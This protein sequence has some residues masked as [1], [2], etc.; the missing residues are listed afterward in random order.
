MRKDGDDGDTK[1]DLDDKGQLGFSRG[2]PKDFLDRILQSAD[3]VGY[4]DI[5]VDRGL[6]S[7]EPVVRQL[8]RRLC[9]E[10][11]VH[12]GGPMMSGKTVWLPRYVF[13]QE[14][15]DNL[16]SAAA[17]ESYHAKHSSSRVNADDAG[18]YQDCFQM[19]EDVRINHK[20]FKDYKGVRQM[21]RDFTRWALDKNKD[22]YPP[23]YAQLVI[24]GTQAEGHGK[25]VWDPVLGKKLRRDPVVQ[26]IVVQARQARGTKH[27]IPLA[28][29]LGEHL[30]PDRQKKLDK[31]KQSREALQKAGKSLQGLEGKLQRAKQRAQDDERRL[32]GQQA[33]Q[34]SLKAEDDKDG[35]AEAEK[36][37][38]QTME[39]IKKQQEEVQDLHEQI[40]KIEQSE[41]YKKASSDLDVAKQEVRELRQVVQSMAKAMCMGLEAAKS[42]LTSFDA[43]KYSETLRQV[44]HD[45]VSRSVEKIQ[46]NESGKLSRRALHKVRTYPEQIW[47]TPVYKRRP[48]ARVV[49]LLDYSGSM[50]GPLRVPQAVARQRKESGLGRMSRI[51]LLHDT[52]IRFAKA[53]VDVSEEY[54]EG[55]VSAAAVWFSDSAYPQWKFGSEFSNEVKKANRLPHSGGGTNLLTA[56]RAGTKMLKEEDDKAC[57]GTLRKL[58]VVLTDTEYYNEQCDKYMENDLPPDM[59]LVCVSIGTPLRDMQDSTRKLFR[60]SVMTE[61]DVEDVLI[62]ALEEGIG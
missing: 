62:T 29:Q 27:V 3:L 23:E 31:V 57:S 1:A 21:Y 56:L 26:G 7:I 44:V 33:R 11:K 30:F 34:E 18:V 60:Y 49:F 9:M 12:D 2:S 59:Q 19:L 51:T 15:A 48:D 20:M 40:D 52:F 42:G 47:E 5:D 36:Q 6:V 35:A 16:L 13:S 24:I 10:V 4:G 22:N 37:A 14:E 38:D 53:L 61:D 54:E 28:V 32:S 58:M 46:Q 43:P 39:R 25:L 50:D 17:H 45:I 55:S 41:D 8:S